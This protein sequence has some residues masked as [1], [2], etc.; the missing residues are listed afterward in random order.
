[1]KSDRVP[2]AVRL[3]AAVLTGNPKLVDK[4]LCDCMQEVTLELLPIIN[5][6]PTVDLPFVAAAMV[7]AANSLRS[8]MN[9]D[10]QK[11]MD[12]LVED[13]QAVA[14][15]MTELAKQMGGVTRRETA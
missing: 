9:K 15:N 8:T 2:F 3:G 14:I 11:V 7:V 12:S 6:R 10:A 13:T 4:T 5:G 1:M